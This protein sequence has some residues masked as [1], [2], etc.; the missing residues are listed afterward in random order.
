ML[1]PNGRRASG[2]ANNLPPAGLTGPGR[3]IHRANDSQHL[4][5]APVGG[6]SMSNLFN[7]P[8]AGPY[9]AVMQ[10]LLNRI[11]NRVRR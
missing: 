1:R 11:K 6:A 2:A 10:L 4:N 5:A 3:N 9:Q 7:A 8:A